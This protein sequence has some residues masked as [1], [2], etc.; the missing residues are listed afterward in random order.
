MKCEKEK[1]NLREYLLIFSFDSESWS[2]IVIVS[3]MDDFS[4]SAIEV[5]VQIGGL[6]GCIFLLI[7]F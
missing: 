5:I 4:L 1:M 7:L 2:S 3:T 6:G